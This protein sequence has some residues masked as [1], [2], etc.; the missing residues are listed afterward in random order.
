MNFLA[1]AY[2][3][4]E[5]PEIVTGNLITDFMRGHKKEEF[6]PGIQH[7][8]ELHHKID[9]FTDSHPATLKAKEFLRPVTGRYCDVFMDVVYDHFLATDSQIFPNSKLA[10]FSQ[11]TYSL[12]DQYTVFFPEGFQRIFYYMKK[13]DWLYYYHTKKGIENSFDAIF[14]R[15]KYLEKTNA[16]YKAFHTYYVEFQN[17]YDN[18]MPDMIVQ[19]KEFLS[20]KGYS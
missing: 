5:I 16:V 13:E 9:T 15:A 12:L 3:S 2:L 18:F 8:I 19:A 17:A 14:R 4:F 10:Q 1:H 20:T 7:G 6:L 11:N